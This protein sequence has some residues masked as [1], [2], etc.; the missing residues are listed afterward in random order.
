MFCRDKEINK[1]KEEI[2]ELKEQVN[3]LRPTYKLHY[4]ETILNDP[5]NEYK[6]MIREIEKNLEILS[7]CVEKKEH[8]LLDKKRNS[9]NKERKECESSGFVLKGTVKGNEEIWVKE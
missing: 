2:E 3:Q 7:Y 1:L 5:L 4:L 6:R 9:Y 8:V